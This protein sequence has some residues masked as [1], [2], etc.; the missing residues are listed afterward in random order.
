MH[1]KTDV[2]I[3]NDGAFQYDVI[4]G[5]DM[6]ANSTLDL[7]AGTVTLHG[8]A[9]NFYEKERSLNSRGR[10]KEVLSCSECLVSDV[11]WKENK[12]RHYIKNKLRLDRKALRKGDHGS[13]NHKIEGFKE[14]YGSQVK[15]NREFQEGD[16]KDVFL[17]SKGFMDPMNQ[18]KRENQGR[19]RRHKVNDKRV[20]P[21]KGTRQEND[22]RWKFHEHR[23]RLLV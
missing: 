4:I 23:R 18:V 7:N 15:E 6:L 17:S 8:S 22:D 16:Y 11:L 20:K 21:I 14:I 3:V 5:R 9:I 1:I 2:L 12:N 10:I 13:F 19:E